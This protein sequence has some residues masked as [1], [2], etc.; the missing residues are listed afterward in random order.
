MPFDLLVDHHDT[1]TSFDHL[2]AVHHRSQAR[3]VPL[4]SL[5]FVSFGSHRPAL[6]LP[7]LVAPHARVRRA[8]AVASFN[9]A[10]EHQAHEAHHGQQALEAQVA[11]LK[12][13]NSLTAR[14]AEVIVMS[15]GPMTLLTSCLCAG[16]A[17][18]EVKC[19]WFLT[20]KAKHLKESL[21]QRPPAYQG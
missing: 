1:A 13:D 17:Y 9:A 20:Q 14:E 12:G 5:G 8:A 11:E 4:D 10:A 15:T 19:G 18:M 7:E 21:A 6:D 3:L 16:A 2:A